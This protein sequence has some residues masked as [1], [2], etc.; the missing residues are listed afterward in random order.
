M[1]N[2]KLTA[3]EEIIKLNIEKLAKEKFQQYNLNDWKFVWGTALHQFG[4]CDYKKKTIRMSLILAVANGA[5][6][7]DAF[8]HELAHALTPNDGGHGEEWKAMCVSIGARPERTGLNNI[9]PRAEHIATKPKENKDT[10]Y[11]LTCP[12]CN[13]YTTVTRKSSRSSSCP[14]CTNKYDERFK[15]IWSEPIITFYYK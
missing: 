4:V 9:E 2:L 1:K 14:K 13:F 6:P 8:L 5:D 11:R 15:L 3:N 10:S 7:I 12:C